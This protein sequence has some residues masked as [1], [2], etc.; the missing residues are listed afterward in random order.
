MMMG[1]FG[2][3][4]GSSKSKS[5]TGPKA[6]TRTARRQKEGKTTYVPKGKK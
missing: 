5:W 2:K 3:L 1:F 6:N 4:F